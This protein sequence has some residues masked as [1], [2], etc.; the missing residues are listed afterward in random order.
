MVKKLLGEDADVEAKNEHNATVLMLAAENGRTATVDLLL[1]KGADVEANAEHGTTAVE[2]RLSKSTAIE[3]KDEG[4][5]TACIR[6]AH[7]G[8]TAIVQLLLDK[9]A[10]IEAK[11]ERGSTSLLGAVKNGHKAT[12]ELLL[13][14]DAKIEATNKTDDTALMIAAQTG[15]T[16]LVKV[17]L[18][19]GADVEATNEDGQTA[20]MCAAQLGH[21]ATLEL[22]IRK[23]AATSA[24]DHENKTAYDQADAA[25]LGRAI[26]ELLEP[27]HTPPLLEATTVV[28]NSVDLL[29]DKSTGLSADRLIK[30][31]MVPHST[32]PG[33]AV[34][35]LLK[36]PP[37]LHKS[38]EFTKPKSRLNLKK[39]E[40]NMDLSES[41]EDVVQDL[42]REGLMDEGDSHDLTAAL[43]SATK[44]MKEELKGGTSPDRIRAVASSPIRQKLDP[45]TKGQGNTNRTIEFEP[46]HAGTTI[47][48]KVYHELTAMGKLFVPTMRCRIFFTGE[49]RNGKT[50]TR[51]ALTGEEF[52]RNE[53]STR[54]TEQKGIELLKVKRT[55][56]SSEAC[57]WRLLEKSARSTEHKRAVASLIVG[58]MAGTNSIETLRAIG[59]DRTLLGKIEKKVQ[60]TK[61]AATVPTA[62]A[63][64]AAPATSPDTDGK[65]LQ[66]DTLLMHPR[67]EPAMPQTN[68]LAQKRTHD[69][70]RNPIEH[71]DPEIAEI[72]KEY[73]DNPDATHT[74]NMQMWD[75]G[76][77]L[78]IHVELSSADPHF[79]NAHITCGIYQHLILFPFC[80][81]IHRP[82]TI[83]NAAPAVSRA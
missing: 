76:G 21:S 36:L 44:Q 35:K 26:M 6:A 10:N 39:I 79:P 48:D 71:V 43:R 29:P 53:I 24:V 82:K 18:S 12:V 28:E 45:H 1:G 61:R 59:M 25:Q 54:G 16:E 7:Y 32:Q 23:G 64:A 8:E 68:V 33:M 67:A 70:A 46:G 62:A 3:D 19:N 75:F 11:N 66:E 9:G 49:G 57:D 2:L 73:L 27:N 72:L 40:F 74:L 51:K 37:G 63:I 56:V 60:E 38:D 80:P 52:D 47:S 31:D 13:R 81:P 22:L 15:N 17:L 77:E 34:V 14:K 65:K 30:I 83:L 5:Y 69:A 58:V 42:I 4:G 78:S 55:E 41:T 20:L 50:S